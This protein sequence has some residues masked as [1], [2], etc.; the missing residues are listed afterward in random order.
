MVVVYV[1]VADNDLDVNTSY[2]VEGAYASYDDVVVV[3]VHIAFEH[4]DD[5]DVVVEVVANYYMVDVVL[6]EQIAFDTTF[7]YMHGLQLGVVAVV[8]LAFV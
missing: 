5:D 1:A 3:E 7:D 4:D 8:M 2:V 6:A